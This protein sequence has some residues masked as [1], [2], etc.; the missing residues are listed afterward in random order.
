MLFLLYSQT[1]KTTVF[2]SMSIQEKKC[3]YH[4]GVNAEMQ[5]EKRKKNV[6]SGAIW[7]HLENNDS[8][9]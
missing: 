3:I 8:S 9:V 7:G 2:N 5:T 4:R 1:A 6:D